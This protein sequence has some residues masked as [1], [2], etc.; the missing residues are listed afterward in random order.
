[1]SLHARPA[2]ALPPAR[3]PGAAPELQVAADVPRAPRPRGA[4]E[5]R[6]AA[7]ERV[8]VFGE[9]GARALGAR[10]RPRACRTRRHAVAL[11]AGIHAEDLPARPQ[12]AG[13]PPGDL[14]SPRRHAGIAGAA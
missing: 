10:A 9:G 6:P 11:A 3:L 5:R 2:A 13:L 12:R 4:S 1:V 7:R 14:A 8:R